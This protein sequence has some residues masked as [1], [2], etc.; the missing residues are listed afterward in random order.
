MLPCAFA[1]GPACYQLGYQ[2]CMPWLMSLIWLAAALM[3]SLWGLLLPTFE[4][5]T[6]VLSQGPAGQDLLMPLA[7]AYYIPTPMFY[8]VLL[9]Q[10]EW[11]SCIVLQRA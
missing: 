2:G 4:A 6:T 3:V 8:S 9:S 7:A 10:C 11:A 1:Q 5:K